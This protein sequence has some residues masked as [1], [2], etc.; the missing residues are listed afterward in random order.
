MST[1]K[2]N[3]YLHVGLPKTG[4]TAIQSA[5]SKLNNQGLL[6]E[7]GFD[8]FSDEIW[9]DIHEFW[10]T[11]SEE[12]FINSINSKVKESSKENIL[13]SNEGLSTT[14]EYA[15]KEKISIE[16]LV[17]LKKALSEFNVKVIIYLRRQDLLFES[18]NAQSI[19][20]GFAIKF[21]SIHDTDIFYKKFLDEV[22][23]LYGKENIIVKVYD[24]DLLYK[25]D[26]V[27]DF[28]NILNLD[29]LISE[30]QIHH[31]NESLSIES[32]KIINSFSKKYMLSEKDASERAKNIQ[33]DF[34]E[35]K[36]SYS[37]YI[38]I[39][40]FLRFGVDIRENTYR[41]RYIPLLLL[42]D[43]STHGSV[44]YLSED[45]R[46]AIWAQYAED[47]AVVARE[48]FGRE[49][50]ILFNT[51]MP[52]RIEKITEPSTSDI[53]CTFMP[54][55][56]NLDERVE[57]LNHSRE[58]HSA[59]L[60]HHSATLEHHSVTFGQLTS[61]LSHLSNVIVQQAEM[62][63]NLQAEQQ[64]MLVASQRRVLYVKKP[65]KYFPV[66]VRKVCNKLSFQDKFPR[67]YALLINI[68]H[69]FNFWK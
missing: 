8:F 61:Q 25:N 46:K 36:L 56:G 7:K 32:L 39:G 48:Y 58:H 1:S 4:T 35:D 24:R 15:D 16:F 57:H 34:N 50:G 22:A 68:Y 27:C 17:L 5:L 62:I 67:C 63:S 12:N 29:D 55:F 66:I 20:L 44:G 52:K 53:V 2:K 33:S 38:N 40:A 28:L 43:S 59:T 47:N 26:S 51:K 49:D 42:G 6:G 21:S 18:W 45:E 14:R 54:I 23:E 19:K 65:W 11:A 30:A 64:A 13:I 69:K 10:T 60:E 31:E 41:W 37:D 9:K 3:I